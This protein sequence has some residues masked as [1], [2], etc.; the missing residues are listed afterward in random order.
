MNQ[1][2][3]TFQYVCRSN[4]NRTEQNRTEQNR[5]EQNRKL[6]NIDNIVIKKFVFS[7]ILL[8]LVVFFQSCNKENVKPQTFQNATSIF[9]NPFNSQRT[10]GV[11]NFSVT[12]GRICFSSM[13]DYIQTLNF[14]LT[15]DSADVAQFR[16]SVTIE[17]PNKAYDDFCF[18]M[19]NASD[20]SQEQT[21]VNS[22]ANKVN[23]RSS[24]S[25]FIEKYIS[26]KEI[27]N[28]NGE[29][30]AGTC[31]FKEY[32]GYMIQVLDGSISKLQSAMN[33]LQSD[34]INGLLVHEINLRGGGCSN[35]CPLRYY[36]QK[37][38]GSPLKNRLTLSYGITEDTYLADPLFNG[39][40][41]KFP[42][43]NLIF[44]IENDFRG[45]L[46]FWYGDKLYDNYK[47]DFSLSHACNWTPNP[48]TD[49][50]YGV[51]SKASSKHE[52]VYPI[53]NKGV[54]VLYP[55]DP[56]FCMDYVRFR[57]TRTKSPWIDIDYRCN[58]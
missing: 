38:V 40:V 53:A 56:A 45:F 30:K 35:K 28:L 42:V 15:A 33:T 25:T 4:S 19:S 12:N 50:K 57:G 31:L 46:G 27:L 3:K 13:G 36:E 44:S 34:S 23:F 54:G 21:I 16:N 2:P 47:V 22:F 58:R 8:L 17:T 18:Q 6:F 24:D 39:N 48:V 55:F 9:P 43:Y 11:G 10:N 26:H 5:T 14:L 52:W 41:V 20:A 51:T 37:A 32:N 29:F 49:Y 1:I 7:T